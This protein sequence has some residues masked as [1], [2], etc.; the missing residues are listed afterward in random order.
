MTIISITA[1][2][3]QRFDWK[4]SCEVWEIVE[5]SRDAGCFHISC[6]Y[7]WICILLYILYFFILHVY[8]PFCSCGCV[9]FITKSSGKKKIFVF[10]VSYSFDKMY[11]NV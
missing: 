11:Y 1:Y 10:G 2:Y 6:A 5:N 7:V 9:Q 3:C 8:G 4:Y